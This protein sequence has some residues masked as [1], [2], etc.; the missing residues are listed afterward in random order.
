VFG[1]IESTTGT[2]L[3]NARQT[4]S[5]SVLVTWWAGFAGYACHF[6]S[7]ITDKAAFCRWIVGFDLSAANGFVFVSGFLLAK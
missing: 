6:S 3:R 5:E 7:K 1:G 2:A 4:V